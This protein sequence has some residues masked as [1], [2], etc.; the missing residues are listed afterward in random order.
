M[1]TFFDTIRRDLDLSWMGLAALLVL[2]M[3][4]S[5]VI[6]WVYEMLFYHLDS[7]GEWVRRGHGMGPWLPI[8]GFGAL[9]IMFSCW[10]IRTLPL[11]VIL[12]SALVTGLLELVTGWVLYHLFG[13]IR[14]WDYNVEIW[15]WGNIGGYVCFRSVAVFALVGLA[16]MVLVV[17]LT[18]ALILRLGDRMVFPFAVLLGALY[19]SDYVWGYFVK[20][21]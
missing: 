12:R 17:P 15:N 7:G 4:G 1:L 20:G 11:R 3:V 9:G 16:L 2:V 21:F 14:W 5:A 13:G 19:L 8:Y 18:A 10:D 6:G